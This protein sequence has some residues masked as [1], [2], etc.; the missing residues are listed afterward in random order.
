MKF[1]Q[2]KHTNRPTWKTA[3]EDRPNGSVWFKTTSANSGANIVVKLYSTAD[4]S[5]SSVSAP[6]YATNHQAIYNLDPSN[7]GT[8]LSVGDLYTQF[9][10][11]EQSVDGQQDGTPN[12]GD[13]QVFR[14][15]GGETIIQ[16]KTTYPSFTAN[17]TFTV[18]ESLK[19]QEALDTARTVTMVSGDGSTLGDQEDFVTAFNGAGFTNLIACLLYT[20]PSPRDVEESRMPS[21]A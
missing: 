11:T 10:I 6:L 21:S 14:Y 17:E 15:E 9:N 18:R 20:S 2:A 16:S 7:G 1:L 13:F 19:N 3:D 12:V 5:F 8:A 4:G